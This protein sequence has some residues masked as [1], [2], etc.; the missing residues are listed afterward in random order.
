MAVKIGQLV[1]PWSAELAVRA[2]PHRDGVG[3][4]AGHY[5]MLILPEIG[6]TERH[7][8]D[9]AVEHRPLAVATEQC[10]GVGGRVH[11]V[12]IPPASVEAEAE[13]VA[14]R[15][16]HREETQTRRDGGR[17]DVDEVLVAQVLPR[18]GLIELARGLGEGPH[19]LH[20]DAWR[21]ERLG[22][23]RAI[24][25]PF[26]HRPEHLVHGWQIRARAHRQLRIRQRL[27]EPRAQ[28]GVRHL[29]ARRTRA[30]EFQAEVGQHLERE[31]GVRARA[32]GELDVHHPRA[33]A[34]PHRRPRAPHATV[35]LL[36]PRPRAHDAALPGIAR[37][38][39]QSPEAIEE[40][41]ARWRHG[42]IISQRLRRLRTTREGRTLARAPKPWR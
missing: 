41:G 8:V 4:R 40:D 21:L 29:Q 38:P 3:R 6:V 30:H 25:R 31:V 13:R 35:R 32:L 36:D 15:A 19:P 11:G 33:E 10:F 42:P 16:E 23:G 18:C 27:P 39:R 7:L 24:G 37:A 5:E 28:R 26:L 9:G 34:D 17:L 2:V 22:Q 14:G 20:G 12:E 1:R